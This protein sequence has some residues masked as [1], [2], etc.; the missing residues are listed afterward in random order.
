MGT[1]LLIKRPKCKTEILIGKTFEGVYV[2]EKLAINKSL[3]NYLIMLLK[4]QSSSVKN[5]FAIFLKCFVVEADINVLINMQ[6]WH[7]MFMPYS[8]MKY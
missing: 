6:E 5:V 7:F 4:N 3:Y 8:E 1:L 2:D